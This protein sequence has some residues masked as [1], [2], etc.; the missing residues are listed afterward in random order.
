MACRLVYNVRKLD[1]IS[2][3]L[4]D[5]HW[6]KVKECITCKIA[7]TGKLPVMKVNNPTGPCIWNSLPLD[8]RKSSS[9]DVFKNHL[10]TFLFSQSYDV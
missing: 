7:A 6:L 10:K 3:H 2:P 8:I 4:K 1:S 5:L 9:L